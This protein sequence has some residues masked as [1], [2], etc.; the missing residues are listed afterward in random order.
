[1]SIYYTF[2]GVDSK[3]VLQWA[4]SSHFHSPCPSNLVASLWRSGCALQ[5]ISSL[6]EP[7]QSI[8]M[9]T[10]VENIAVARL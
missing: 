3:L 6:P 5:F 7:G 2:S 4:S 1:M 8:T 9:M 10:T